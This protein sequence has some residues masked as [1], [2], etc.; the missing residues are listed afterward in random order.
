MS[1]LYYKTDLVG[2]LMLNSMSHLNYT[3]LLGLS[4]LNSMS[5]LNYTDLLGLWMLNSMSHL[6]YTDLLGL[7]MLNS[8][9]H[10]N[11][12]DLLGLS[13]LNSMSHLNYTDLLGLS[14]L[15]LMRSA[16][17]SSSFLSLQNSMAWSTSLSLVVIRDSAFFR[18]PIRPDI[19]QGERS[20]STYNQHTS[21]NHQ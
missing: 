6:N 1:H 17:S 16:H 2:L 4:M 15:N 10:L 12:T 8:M 5:H 7:S 18:S 21:R 3:Y 19:N 11:Y 20:R 14:M 13:I 9:S